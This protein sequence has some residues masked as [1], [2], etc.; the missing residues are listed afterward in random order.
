VV[1]TRLA[2]KRKKEQERREGKRGESE[3]K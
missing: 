2:E 3:A 1:N